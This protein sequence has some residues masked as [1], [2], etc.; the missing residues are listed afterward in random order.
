MA[1]RHAGPGTLHPL[2]CPSCAR[3]F[4]AT[5]EYLD[6]TP[7]SG[8][9]PPGGD[10]DAAKYWAGTQI[11]RSPLVA[12]V[13][14]RGWRQGFAWA[15][16]PGADAEFDVAMDYFRAVQGADSTLLDLSCGS[17]LFAR[18]F[19]A[20]Q[21]FGGGVVVA[22]YSETMLAQAIAGLK[23]DGADPGTY[24]PLRLDA[25]RLPFPAA[26]LDAV[27]AGAALHC[28]PAPALAVAEVGRV[29]RPGGVFVAST[30]LDAAAPLGALLG[31]GAAGALVRAAQF[32]GYPFGSSYRW[33]TEDELRALCAAA[34]LVDFRRWR[35]ARFILFS[36]RKPAGDGG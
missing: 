33:W 29:L 28:W 8:L 30:F 5:T 15:G 34:G 31:D 10:G 13:Y 35:R 21:A 16:F 3:T 7:A 17:G 6:L 20:S 32:G 36:A 4:A 14:D 24:L 18:R 25:G 19:V 22:D 23:A 9:G 1:A 12:A 27:H 11:F 26:S 2:R